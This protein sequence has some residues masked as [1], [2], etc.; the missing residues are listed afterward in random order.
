[1][2]AGR[3]GL[4]LAGALALVGCAGLE[5][6]YDSRVCWQRAWWGVWPDQCDHA[7]LAFRCSR[8][9]TV[10]R[11]AAADTA[12][13]VRMAR[14]GQPPEVGE[15]F[16]QHCPPRCIPIYVEGPTPSTVLGDDARDIL[17][18]AGYRIAAEPEGADAELELRFEVVDVRSA[19]P[20]FWDMKVSTRAAVAFSGLLRGRDGEVVWSGRFPAGEEIRHSYAALADSEAI[21]SGAYCAA[22]QQFADAV[23]GAEIRDGLARRHRDPQAPP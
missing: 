17:G 9:I 11:A 22:L 4:A 2:D 12:I 13:V 3:T 7:T 20:G 19:Q 1:M 21:L 10:E 8:E 23:S 5:E 16:S 14:A 6:A 15:L 18:R